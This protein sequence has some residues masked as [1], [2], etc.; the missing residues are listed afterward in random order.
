MTRLLVHVEGETEE[1]FVNKLLAPYLYG[2]GFSMVSACL[3]GNARQRERRGGIRPWGEVR[4]DIVNH[5]R[6][7]P[8]CVA[9]TMV[10]YYGLP[11]KNSRAWPGRDKTDKLV[12]SKKALTV[13]AA[14]AQDVGIEMGSGFNRDRFIPY[15]MMHEFEALLFSDCD[16][17]ASAIGRPEVASS[18][19]DIRNGF[20]SP[21]EIDD[22]PLS[23]PS[24]RILALVP[25]YRKPLHGTLAALEV[26]LQKICS[27]CPHFAKWL[28]CLKPR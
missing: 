9:T 1:S 19:Q 17:F 18:F 8:G 26:G 4:R 22:S 27:E 5:L 23:A 15:V 14:L 3:I 25:G 10:D 7:D 2:R 12:F 6:E 11:S 24:K 20:S 28:T 13:E 16:K 21:E